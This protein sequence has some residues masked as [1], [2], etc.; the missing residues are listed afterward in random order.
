[1]FGRQDQ[2]SYKHNYRYLLEGL[3]HEITIGIFVI[4]CVTG[5]IIKD[6]KYQYTGA[7]II[8]TISFIFCILVIAGKLTGPVAISIS[9]GKQEQV[10]IDSEYSIIKLISESIWYSE[11]TE[12]KKNLRR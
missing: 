1:M 8:S 3:E 5:Y 6:N 4:L 2:E 11:E 10:D 9:F 7:T 12:P